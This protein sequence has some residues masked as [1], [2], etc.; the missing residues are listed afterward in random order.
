MSS[1]GH[2]AVLPRRRLLKGGATLGLGLL[3][4]PNAWGQKKTIK[5]AF[6]DPLT[7]DLA[8]NG[9]GGRNSFLLA[10]QER[11]ADPKAK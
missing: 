4:A 2:A 9:L 1:I 5:I 8:S 6:I 3:A 7:G 11:N 10:L